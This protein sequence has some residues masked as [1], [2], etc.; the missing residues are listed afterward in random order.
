M[1]TLH[2]VPLKISV[3]KLAASIDCEVRYLGGSAGGI[4]GIKITCGGINITDLV[5]GKPELQLAI[6]EQIQDHED[7]TRE[8]MQDAARMAFC[9]EG[10]L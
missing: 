2:D 6:M 8:R 10:D 5:M 4:Y 7:S 9:Y 3:G 1:N